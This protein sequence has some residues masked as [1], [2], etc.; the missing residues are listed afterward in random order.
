METIGEQSKSH[1]RTLKGKWRQNEL[2][3]RFVNLWND[4]VNASR[5]PSMGREERQR[6]ERGGNE[7]KTVI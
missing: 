3:C 2:I 7:E 4:Q 1:P 5:F 6:G